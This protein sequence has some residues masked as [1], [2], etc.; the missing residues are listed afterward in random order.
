MPHFGDSHTARPIDRRPHNGG[1][2]FPPVRLIAGSRRVD[3]GRSL[4]QKASEKRP[5]GEDRK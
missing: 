5:T 2:P 4:I 1:D 3:A